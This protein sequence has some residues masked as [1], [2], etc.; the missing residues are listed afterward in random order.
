MG[1]A[2]GKQWQWAAVEVVL[3]KKFMRIVCVLR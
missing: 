1:T 2:E 3:G